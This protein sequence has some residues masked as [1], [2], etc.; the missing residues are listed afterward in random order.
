MLQW[1]PTP[2]QKSLRAESFAQRSES[3]AVG[4]GAGQ[5]AVV[6]HAARRPFEKIDLQIV[7]APVAYDA[8]REIVQPLLDPGVR[9]IEGENA[10][11]PWL[12]GIHDEGSPVGRLGGTLEEPG[13]IRSRDVR[14]L[15]DRE[16]RHP[17][18]CLKARGMHAIG[19]P[20]VAMGKLAVRIPIAG[21]ALVAVVELDVAKEAAV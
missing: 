4:F 18:A 19:Q 15:G 20:P 12:A 1:R 11:A 9:A 14:L 21:G 6:G 7:V 8:A 5:A 2:E 16:G 17:Q 13:W 10:A 3:A